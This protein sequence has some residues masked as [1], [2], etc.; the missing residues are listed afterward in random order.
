MPKLLISIRD[1]SDLNLPSDGYVLGYEKYTSFAS[2]CFTYEEIKTVKNKPI[3]ILLN[4]LIHE[5]D[6][7]AVKKEVD[8]LIKLDVN[9][10][11]Q[12]VGLLTYLLTS[13]NKD[14]VLFFPYT[15]IC[16]KEELEAYYLSFGVASYISNE[17]TLEE[18]KETLKEGHGV[19][20]LFGHTPIYQSYRKV[21]SLYEIEK[22]IRF[23]SKDLYLKENT[24]GEH[25]PIIE[26]EYGSVIFRSTPTSLLEDYE[27]IKEAEYLFV[28]SIFLSHEM[29]TKVVELSNKVIS[30]EIDREY[31]LK[32]YKELGYD[33][34]E[35]FKHHKTV[36]RK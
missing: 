35:G 3:Y 15:L 16:N 11:V 9:F 29:F 4:A 33:S 26:N 30:G 34:P 5:K 10:I 2:H 21:L 1:L 18:M 7:E 20:S 13:V 27:Y 28:D 32:E 14:K 8:R 6:I 25:Y 24:R 31:I 22:K 12:D 23:E 36:L 19:V 17:I